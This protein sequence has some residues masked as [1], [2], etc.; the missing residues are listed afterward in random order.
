M[1]SSLGGIEMR[2]KS[3]WIEGLK[4]MR[5]NVFLHGHKVERDDESMAGPINTIGTTFDFAQKPEHAELMIAESHLSGEPINRFCHI[6]QSKEDLHR[7]QDMTRLLCQQVG[8]CIQRCMGVDAANAISCASYEADR[9]N[10]GA[11][12]Y[13]QNFLRWLARFQSEDLVGCC[14]QTD[15]KGDRTLRPSQQPDPDAYLHVVEK[16]SDGIVV[17]GCKVHI[18]VA[19]QADEIL[20]V[21]TRALLPEEGD[22]AVAFAVPGDW[23][24]MKLVVRSTGQRPRQHFEKG[25]EQG[26]TEAMVIFE[27][28]FIPWERVFLCGE[29]LH[30]GILALLFALYHRHSYTGCKPAVSELLMGTVALAAE[31][32]NVEKE[33]HIRDKLAEMIQVTELAYAAGFTASEK[34]AARVFM[35]GKGLVPYGP[36]TYIP[37]SIFCN[38]GRCLSG[39]AYYHELET[40]ADVSGGAPATLPYEEDW[41]NPE[42]RELIEKYSRRNPQVSPH[43][44]NLLWRHIGDILC[45]AYGGVMAVAAVHGGGSPIMEKIAITSQYDIAERKEMVKRLAGIKP[46]D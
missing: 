11:S 2:S 39:E 45:S 37:D 4:K 16:K 29:T 9:T 27:D 14:A 25:F 20:V 15:M 10:K 33:K 34:G 13:Y 44:Q 23:E 43:E 12:E 30:G 18:T 7:K 19:P 8:G 3:Q 5:R 22:W 35:P 32:N 21:P 40:L 46:K 38:V 24:G 42:I 31:Y 41:A 26:T 17:R 36:G 1:E 6:H 28:A